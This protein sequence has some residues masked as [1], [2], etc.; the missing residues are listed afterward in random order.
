M[1]RAARS[2][3]SRVGGFQPLFV[4]LIEPELEQNI[5]GF[6]RR[7]GGQFAAP[8]ALRRLLRGERVHRALHGARDFFT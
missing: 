8:E 3:R 6:Q 7:V 1:E 5:I 4:R 2:M